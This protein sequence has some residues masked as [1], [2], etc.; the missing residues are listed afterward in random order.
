MA[1]AHVFIA[2]SL[3]G[4]IARPDGDIDGTGVDWTRLGARERYQP[5]RRRTRSFLMPIKP[6]RFPGGN[7]G[8]T[9]VVSVDTRL[10]LTDPGNLSPQIPPFSPTSIRATFP[11]SLQIQ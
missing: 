11:S 3:D 1:T 6:T 4:F 7:R 9:P 2:V 5:S 10:T 8:Q